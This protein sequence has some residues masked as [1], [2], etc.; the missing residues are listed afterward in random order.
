MLKD[1]HTKGCTNA[2]MIHSNSEPAKT[3]KW[4]RPK[5]Y[6]KRDEKK[7]IIIIIMNKTNRQTEQNNAREKRR[8]AKL[9]ETQENT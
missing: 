5:I 2:K 6:L 1:S 9:R 4:N 8:I 7:K 3:T